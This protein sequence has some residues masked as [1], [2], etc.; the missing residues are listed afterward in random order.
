MTLTPDWSAANPSNEVVLVGNAVNFDRSEERVF[1]ESVLFR[2][3]VAKT[4]SPFQDRITVDC[5]GN[6]VFVVSEGPDEAG[7]LF[8]LPFDNRHH[9]VLGV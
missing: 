9:P 5:F 7:E 8:L 1:F 6:S 3:K 2:L 4:D